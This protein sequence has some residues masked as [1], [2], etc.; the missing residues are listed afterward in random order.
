MSRYVYIHVHSNV[1]HHI[2]K[3][4][5]THVSTDRRVVQHSLVHTYSGVFALRRKE[6]DTVLRMEIDF[7]DLML[8]EIR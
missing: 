2:Q 6:T 3:V 1:I 5:V 8:S 4:E 7:E